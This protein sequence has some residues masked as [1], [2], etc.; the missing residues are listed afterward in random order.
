MTNGESL[1]AIISEKRS[2]LEVE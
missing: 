2:Y 1:S